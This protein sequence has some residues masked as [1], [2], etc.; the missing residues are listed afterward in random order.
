VPDVYKKAIAE[1][2]LEPVAEPQ[3]ELEKE[4]PV[5]IKAV[6]PLKPLVNL[7]DYKTIDLKPQPVE[8]TEDMVNSVIEQLRK[9]HAT[10]EPAE[11][12]VEF[13]DLVT[14]D[15]ESTM[16]GEPF[17][18][19]KGVQYQVTMGNISPA[20]GFAEQLVGMK[21]DEEKECKLQYPADYPQKEVQGNEAT[22]KVKISEIKQEKLPEVND[23]FAKQVGADITGVDVMRQKITEDLKKRVEDRCKSDFEDKVIEAVTAMSQ[24][25]YP[26]ILVE[27]EVE[28]SLERNLRF[29]QSTGQNIE[30]YLKSIDKTID[31]LREE[32]KPAAV[33]RVAESLV[34]G[35]ISEQEKIEVTHAEID[36]EIEEMVKNS[37]GDK[38][39]LRKALQAQRNHESVEDT[40]VARKTVQ[41]LTEIAQS[42]KEAKKEA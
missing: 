5:I 34:V 2:K 37:T 33:K 10:W 30:T 25:E 6:V 7:G 38:D 17:V 26:P 40:L 8:V 1:Q 11:R 20:P 31:Q 13:N 21:K 28:R 23:E 3:I 4:D 32:L 42:Q 41:R 12:P 9:Q 22:F 19:Q 18:N 36:A 35:R 15:V 27:V 29:L 16:K 14:L 24:V 39:E